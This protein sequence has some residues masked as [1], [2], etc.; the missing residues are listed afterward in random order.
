MSDSTA[1]VE[2]EK[3]SVKSSIQLALVLSLVCFAFDFIGMFGGF[4]IF[5]QSINL[6]HIVL[7]FFGGCWNSW[8]ILYEWK[9]EYLWNSWVCFNLIPALAEIG[10]LISI[11]VLKIVPF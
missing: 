11:F 5:F 10:V 6:M 3:A 2:A 8:F 7:H 1:S 9:Y 4:S